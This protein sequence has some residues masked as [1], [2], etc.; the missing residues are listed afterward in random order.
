MEKAEIASSTMSK[1]GVSCL[2]DEKFPRCLL[3]M[4]T[5]S[6]IFCYNEAVSIPLILITTCYVN[7]ESKYNKFKINLVN[8][9]N[10]IANYT[11]HR[12]NE[13]FLRT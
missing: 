8:E 12:E 9:K 11:S 7:L 4:T 13:Y 3:L 10:F 2:K 1:Q 5:L 6:C